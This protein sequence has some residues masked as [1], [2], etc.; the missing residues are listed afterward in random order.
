MNPLKPFNELP[1]LPPNVAIETPKLLKKAIESH[2]E[3]AELKGLSSLLPNQSVL[4]QTIGLQEAKLSS[5]IENIVTTNDEL[6]RAFA[7]EGQQTDPHTKEVLRYNEALWYGYQVILNRNQL[8]TPPLFEELASIIT[9][10]T[11]S[12][13][14]L[15]GTQLKNPATGQVIYTPPEGEN[16]IRDKLSNLCRFI[17]EYSEIDPL[18]KLALIHYQFEAIHP[19]YDGNGRSGRIINILFLIEQSLLSSPI[20]YLSKYIIENKQSYYT[21]LKNVTEKQEWEPWILFILEAVALTAKLTREKILAIK[22]L[23]EE[24]I[25]KIKKLRPKIYSKDL[26]EALFKHPYCKI[27]FLEDFQIAKRQTASLY[28]QELENIGILQGI[29]KSRDKYY[30]NHD[31]LRLLIK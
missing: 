30:I 4:I 3:L 13:R 23:M 31:F 6:Y 20:L 5:E 1:F 14:K 18:I 7:D 27:Q 25:E 26:V 16:L 15:T 19:F 11:S 21:L 12:I 17:Y 28:L 24:T 22:Q 10:Q 9:G 2:K 8:L 29:K